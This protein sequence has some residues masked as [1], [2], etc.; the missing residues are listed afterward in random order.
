[1][2]VSALETGGCI[3][4]VLISWRND[5]GVRRLSELLD[6]PW[7]NNVAMKSN[8]GW[9][10]S[11]QSFA[12]AIVA[13]DAPDIGYEVNLRV[14]EIFRRNPI[15]S[16]R[17][18]WLLSDAVQRHSTRKPE[19]VDSKIGLLQQ[20]NRELEAQSTDIRENDW[21]YAR[22]AAFSAIGAGYS[23][24]GDAAAAASMFK[25]SQAEADRIS[26]SEQMKA[27]SY[28][29]LVERCPRKSSARAEIE[30]TAMLF[31]DSIG[32]EENRSSLADA[33]LTT[34][35]LQTNQI[36]KLLRYIRSTKRWT[37]SDFLKT[38]TSLISGS[39]SPPSMACL[40]LRTAASYSPAFVKY[41]IAETVREMIARKE[42]PNEEMLRL[43]E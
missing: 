18:A 34:A 33:L 17:W 10:A 35:D 12:N 37:L 4:R 14:S 23:A 21:L 1:L 7:L 28:R 15:L 36:R 24:C 6:K 38:S 40:L 3:C 9:A 20:A 13:V 42:A 5:E 19:S 29:E 31:V 30:R 2:S 11:L 8:V 16:A 39:A 43:L 26:G 22:A 25:H 32:D 41:T 27:W